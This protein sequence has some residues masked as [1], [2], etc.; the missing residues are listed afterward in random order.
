MNTPT[1]PLLV[2]PTKMQWKYL[3]LV[4]SQAI[5]IKQVIKTMLTLD[6][7]FENRDNVVSYL[8]RGIDVRERVESNL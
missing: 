4:L 3:E 2:T 6:T 1:V 5:R 8:S 7:Q